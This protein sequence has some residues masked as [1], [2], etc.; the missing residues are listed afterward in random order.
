MKLKKFS[1][2]Q[3]W[4]KLGFHPL[5]WE[6]VSEESSLEHLIGK[7]FELLTPLFLV[8]MGGIY[9][10]EPPGRFKGVPAS[11]E[12]YLNHPNDWWKTEG[13]RNAIK[14]LIPNPSRLH[15][16]KGIIPKGTQLKI[17]KATYKK[18]GLFGGRLTVF[19]RLEDARFDHFDVCCGTIMR[20]L[21][22][23]EP[24]PEPKTNF[25]RPVP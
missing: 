1:L 17:R 21:I 6:D 24:S 25:I 14:P 10:L 9:C 11:I 3:L 15:T 12:D 13:Y 16:I 4:A 7:K 8:N 18:G 22:G 2:G 19:A 5:F 20:G 23:A